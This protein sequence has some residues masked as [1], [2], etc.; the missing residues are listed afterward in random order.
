MLL[1]LR[2]LVN[3]FSKYI[4]ALFLPLMPKAKATFSR[5]SSAIAY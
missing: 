2:Q 4:A 3:T 5:G 1:L